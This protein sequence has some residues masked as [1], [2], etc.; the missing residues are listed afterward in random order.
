MWSSVKKSARKVTAASR[1]AAAARNTTPSDGTVDDSALIG[2]SMDGKSTDKINAEIK[3]RQWDQFEKNDMP[4]IM[5]YATEITSG[6]HYQRAIDQARDGVERGFGLAES[7]Q[8]MRDNDLGVSLSEASKA[9]RSSDMARNKTAALI[10]AENNAR[11]AAKDR[12]NALIA[13]S[14]MPGGQ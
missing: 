9:D 3:R 11:L 12:E 6:K 1:R 13:G 5:N 7:A 2:D 8:K 10:D 4:Y 14:H